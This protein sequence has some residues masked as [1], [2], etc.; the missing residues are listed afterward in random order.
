MAR[1]VLAV[2]LALVLFFPASLLAMRGSEA[3]FGSGSYAVPAAL[4][5]VALLVGLIWAHLRQPTGAAT[6]ALFG[7][8]GAGLM[9]VVGVLLGQVVGGILTAGLFLVVWYA[10][11]QRMPRPAAS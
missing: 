8:L 4:V 6:A 10:A 2:V 5:M 1:S 9:L 7:L 3:V 11:R